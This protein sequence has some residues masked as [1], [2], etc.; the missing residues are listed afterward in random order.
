MNLVI[1]IRV[2]ILYETL[3]QEQLKIRLD[4]IILYFQS[5]KVEYH[6]LFET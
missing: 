3:T 5:H 6:I 1:I 2:C 4:T